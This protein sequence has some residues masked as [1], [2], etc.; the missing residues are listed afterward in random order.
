M[1]VQEQFQK[2]LVVQ[3]V[4]FQTTLPPIVLKKLVEVMLCQ[5]PL[6]R[7]VEALKQHHRVEVW[8]AGELV[9]GRYYFFSV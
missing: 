7:A 4:Y 2:L 3:L 8:R 6:T 5:E 9:F 1:L